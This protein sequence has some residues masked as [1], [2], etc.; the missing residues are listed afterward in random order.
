MARY[1]S[2]TLLSVASLAAGTAQ[3]ESQRPLQPLA[4]L[5]KQ[6]NAKPLGLY[7]GMRLLRVP[8]GRWRQ[9]DDQRQL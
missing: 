8:P 5:L 2:L 1:L 7:D 4:V 6:L 9:P 3:A